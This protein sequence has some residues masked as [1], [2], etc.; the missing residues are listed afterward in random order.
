MTQ[1]LEAT[2]ERR[3]PPFPRPES[4]LSGGFYRCNPAKADLRVTRTT[5]WL[6]TGIIHSGQTLPGLVGGPGCTADK[7][8]VT[9]HRA[10]TAISMRRLDTPTRARQPRGPRR[11]QPASHASTGNS[12]TP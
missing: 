3:S 7:D 9:A 2:P 4:V 8:D 5:N 1:P 12:T 10:I 11:P 6:L